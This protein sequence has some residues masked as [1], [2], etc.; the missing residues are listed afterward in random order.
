[1]AHEWYGEKAD[2]VEVEVQVRL[3]EEV[4]MS[5]R[6]EQIRFL[7]N[8]AVRA[9]YIF[10]QDRTMVG[11]AE[12][13]N[14]AGI[15]VLGAMI[16]NLGQ[17]TFNTYC[18]NQQRAIGWL[19]S[20]TNPIQAEAREL[21]AKR[22]GN[23]PSVRSMFDDVEREFVGPLVDEHAKNGG[24]APGAEELEATCA[25]LLAKIL[26]DLKLGNPDL[27]AVLRM[28]GPSL[29]TEEREG[30][31]SVQG[32]HPESQTLLLALQ[33]QPVVKIPT[34]LL[35]ALAANRKTLSAREFAGF[36][37][38]L[39]IGNDWPETF[40]KTIRDLCGEHHEW[41]DRITYEWVILKVFM[42]GYGVQ[43]WF[44][45]QDAT[46]CKE[47]LET[48]HG[49]VWQMLGGAMPNLAHKDFVRDMRARYEA[50]YAAMREPDSCAEKVGKAFATFVHGAERGPATFMMEIM[51]GVLA[52][53]VLLA[54]K[55]TLFGG[56][57]RVGSSGF[58][59]VSVHG[60]EDS[61]LKLPVDKS[62]G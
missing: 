60:E 34:E 29:G 9:G 26:W 38:H 53:S 1:M 18:E 37:F 15:A 27:A 30:R 51:G 36:L 52:F 49:H 25:M 43:D 11:S 46:L 23:H 22:R 33:S 45:G 4:P 57:K 31:E 28:L 7:V 41:E 62:P 13:Y 54:D 32:A 21:R 50:F 59:M 24:Q 55:E 35:E 44:G 5:S 42:I 20:K 2:P 58:E 14:R 12:G 61:Q 10:E 17:P 3:P 39:L 48:F 40:R 56:W 6:V 16:L 47:V 8:E 19:Q